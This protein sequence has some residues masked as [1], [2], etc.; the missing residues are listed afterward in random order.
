M[1]KVTHNQIWKENQMAETENGRPERD[2]AGHQF[3]E[4]LPQAIADIQV[5]IVK[6][7]VEIRIKEDECGFYDSMAA[8]ARD[9]ANTDDF[10]KYMKLLE[11]AEAKCD[12]YERRQLYFKQQLDHK[13]T[14]PVY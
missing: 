11:D 13:T 9:D 3:T 6:L 14:L 12:E 2:V 1:A 5:E 8:I 4:L 10:Q 7:E